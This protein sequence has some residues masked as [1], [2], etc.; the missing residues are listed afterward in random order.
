PSGCMQYRK[1]RFLN[2]N[3]AFANIGNRCAELL[4]PVPVLFNLYTSDGFANGNAHPGSSIDI[5]GSTGWPNANEYLATAVANS[6]G[7]WS[8]NVSAQ[9]PFLTGI[10]TDIYNCSSVLSASIGQTTPVAPGST[11]ATAT[12]LPSATYT[13]TGTELQ[14]TGTEYW[15]KFTADTSSMRI[16]IQNPQDTPVA[17]IRKL[18]LFSGDCDNLVE[19][20]RKDK[21]AGENLVINRSDFITGSDYFLK[22]EQQ[23]NITGNFEIC[24]RSI[25]VMNFVLYDSIVCPGDTVTGLLYEKGTPIPQLSDLVISFV[26]GTYD[27]QENPANW[28]YNSNCQSGI[29]GSLDLLFSYDMIHNQDGSYSY[30]LMPFLP[31]GQVHSFVDTYGIT[32]HFFTFV[33]PQN[34]PPGCYFVTNGILIPPSGGNHDTVAVGGFIHSLCVLSS[35]THAHIIASDTIICPGSSVV[36]SQDTVQPGD[37]YNW[38]NSNWVHIGTGNS[39]TVN[40]GF[41]T[42]YYLVDSNKCGKDTVQVTIH[43]IELPVV[44]ISCT[45]IPSSSNCTICA[46][47]TVTLIANITQNPPASPYSYSWYDSNGNF[48]F[49]IP[50]LTVT[51]LVTTTYYVSVTDTCGNSPIAGITVTVNP[52]PVVSMINDTAVC[53]NASPFSLNGAPA[54]G[55]YTEASAPVSSQ[56]N[57]AVASP[58]IHTIIYT[59]TNSSGCSN[60]DTVKITVNT[61]PNVSLNIPQSQVCINSA[62]FPLTGGYP[63]TNLFTTGFGVYSGTGVVQQPGL[64]TYFFNPASAVPGYN[65]ITYTF[66]SLNGCVGSATDMIQ[67]IATPPVP[68]FTIT[69][70]CLYENGTANFGT[71][72]VINPIYGSVTASWNFGDNTTGTGWNPSHTYHTH[73]YHSVTL[74]LTNQCGTSNAC[75]VVYINQLSCLCD[76]D[77]YNIIND[78]TITTNTI[79]NSN[80][81]NSSIIYIQ[82]TVYISPNHTLTIQPGLTLRFGPKGRIVVNRYARLIIVNNV[83]LTSAK[84]NCNAMWQ[85]IEVWGNS[86]Y[87]SAHISQGIVKMGEKVKIIN[88]HIGV[89][90]GK[91]MAMQCGKMP[92]YPFEPN[93]SG[94]IIK[95]ANTA[96]FIN[97]GT[98]IKIL[99][100]GA[101]NDDYQ[102]RI[103]GCIFRTKPSLADPYYNTGN[104]PHYPNKYYPWA[105]TSNISQRTVTGI[106]M[107]GIKM[108]ADSIYGNT[109]RNLQTGIKAFDVSYSVKA[110]TFDTLNTGIRSYHT[111]S[112][113]HVGTISGC[114]FNHITKL[115]GD[116]TNS[117]GIYISGGLGNN[118]LANT[119]GLLSNPDQSLVALGIHMYNSA[120]FTIGSINPSN[121]NKFYKITTGVKV[122]NACTS[123]P[124]PSSVVLQNEF[125]NTR[126]SVLTEQNNSNVQVKCNAFNTNTITPGVAYNRYSLNINIFAHQGTMTAPS[127][128][129][130]ITS[131]TPDIENQYNIYNYYVQICQNMNMN[132]NSVNFN[133]IPTNIYDCNCHYPN[134]LNYTISQ[135]VND[136]VSMKNTL[137]VLQQ[138]YYT[139]QQNLDKGNT[140]ILLNAIAGNTSQG[141]LKNM[142]VSNSPLSD[143]V[144]INVHT[145]NKLSPGNY[146]NVMEINLPVTDKVNP[147]FFN[148]LA[149]LP[150]GIANQ[151]RALQ[152]NNPGGVTTLASI[153]QQINSVKQ[154]RDALLSYL[155]DTLLK[156]NDVATVKQV[157]ES[158]NSISANMTLAAMYIADSNLVAAQNKINAVPNTTQD[159]QDWHEL[160]NLLYN[161]AASGKTLFDIDSL[162]LQTVTE[163]AYSGRSNIAVTNA[164]NILTLLF[165]IEFDTETEG[166]NARYAHVNEDTGIISDIENK[167]A[168]QG[169]Y[170][171]EN[172][173]NPFNNTTVIPYSIPVNTEA[174]IK[175]Y[176][177]TGALLKTFK[178]EHT[179]PS[180]ELKTTNWSNGIYFYSL[181]V[182]GVEI[183]WKKMTLIKY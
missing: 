43:V 71:A 78:T 62:A 68:T 139:V 133:E 177:S 109:F 46:G 124:A 55:I 74:T 100:K 155:L 152:G 140:Q 54:G 23:Q 20:A 47:G 79:W 120:G 22:V 35:Y 107:N 123:N 157:L 97:C 180:V 41:T 7:D 175:I 176:S 82:N 77:Y 106:W 51:P 98:G 6:A 99:K 85:G 163:L 154:D 144:L 42:T 36:L 91:R 24:I 89:L 73:G 86:N 141:N 57:P 161:L 118:I 33:V 88:A 94:G 18:I 19:I 104:T 125:T 76:I 70:S 38:Y 117:A 53:S 44:T 160:Y 137:Q 10:E 3:K 101:N 129:W 9:Y 166:G 84:D 111:N 167:A 40:P 127:G 145:A 31:T 25:C 183:A 173:P 142:L 171:G 26:D 110:C 170:L 182:D 29:D 13:C 72:P 181:T 108:S 87:P 63:V 34:T 90:L 136:L 169:I 148:K 60:S 65:V 121:N 134:F 132:P 146:K 80:T 30:M 81:F 159:L 14:I 151:L 95:E 64:F 138:Q 48:Y 32:Y 179:K 96:E 12:Q 50:S 162:Q 45:T 143:T 16:A 130:F 168:E 119:F 4:M 58:G 11:C 172:Y 67:I 150:N 105:D 2:N 135:S 128:N 115:S 178:L 149:S 49:G 174:V 59:Y 116:I 93:W 56:F 153:Q 1:N 66:T 8:A 75:N 156:T 92:L 5:F 112:N 103:N 21:D 102:C 28:D 69:P 113:L 164:Q 114:S 39:I 126:T 83:T 61:A 52:T 158:E 122:T 37:T 17:N 147:Y 165:N 27:I 131:Q 15:M